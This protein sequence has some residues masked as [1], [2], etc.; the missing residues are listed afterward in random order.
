MASFAFQGSRIV[1]SHG[2]RFDWLARSILG[3]WMEIGPL[4]WPPMMLVF[5]RALRVGPRDPKTWL[6]C[7]LAI[8]PIIVFTAAAIW[9]PLGWHFHWQGP[10]YLYLFPLLGKVAAEDMAR[11]NRGTRT[12]LTA[13]AAVL[14]VVAGLLG[15][16]A[17]T[18]WMHAP[19]SQIEPKRPY[20]DTNPTRE[21]LAWTPLRAALDQRGLLSQP[22]LFVVANKWF[23]AGHADAA[24]GDRLPVV[25]LSQDPR[26]IAY[27]W[28][29]QAFQGWDALIVVPSNSKQNAVRDYAPYFRSITPLADVDVP[30]GGE[31]ALT[32]HVLRGHDYWRAYP[33]PDGLSRHGRRGEASGG[34]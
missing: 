18:G 20:Y 17:A 13:A 34:P 28:D 24:I 8:V 22:R 7:C 33:L 32:L 21:T 5:F 29:D 27:V 9:A 19:L 4:I 6:L 16:Q 25:S 30:L 1:R 26:N 31:S 11:E 10:G 3:Q 14:V 15:S 23:E 2:L 12:W